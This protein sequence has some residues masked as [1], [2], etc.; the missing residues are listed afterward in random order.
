MLVSKA[1]NL[2]DAGEGLIEA[3]IVQWLVQVGDA[4]ALNQP[5]VEIETMK[6]LVELP[7]PFAGVVSQLLVAEGDTVAVGRPILLIA[8]ETDPYTADPSTWPIVAETPAARLDD[9]VAE[10]A[11]VLVG[12]GP[13]D[14]RP[15]RRRLAPAAATPEISSAVPAAAAQAPL[16]DAVAS[17]SEDPILAK[18]PVRQLAHDL[19]VDLAAVR[20]TGLGGIVTR[21]DVTAAHEQQVPDRRAASL[22]AD[23][24]QP[25]GGQVSSDGRQ[26]RVPI[27][28]VRK[29]TAE[30]MVMSAFTAPHVTVFHTLD[31]T[32]TM[33]LVARL[34]ADKEFADVHVTPLLI[35]AKALLIAVGRHPEINASWDEASGEI[36][37]KHYIN[38][39]IAAAT[40]RGLIVPNIKDAHRLGLHELAVALNEL[41]AT[42]R[43][44]ATSPAQ[45]LDGT[46]TI[47]NVGVFSID[48]GTP[49]LNP[50]EAAILAFGAISE[51]PW[52]HHG[53]LR[54]RWVTQLAL[55]FD[56]RLVDGGLGSIVLSDVARLLGDPAQA[57]VWG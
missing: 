26:T 47:T 6:S 7:C 17:P 33:K 29:R 2:P 46:I 57:L 30:A 21:E 55:S 1:F 45:L 22:G 28:S 36:V 54:A 8:A 16:S 18:P 27:R 15:R 49:I 3:E 25:L 10:P 23:Q 14:E 37:Y 42:A 41:T 20:P 53:K 32:K 24:P 31:M 13:G 9:A 5:V 38:L 39:G 51:R 35:V 34:R 19:G 11:R 56:H 52:V 50:G 43:A 44:D 48:T 12:Y 4:V 40:P